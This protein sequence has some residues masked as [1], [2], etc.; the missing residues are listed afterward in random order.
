[1]MLLF[2]GYLSLL[3]DTLYGKTRVVS[4][5]ITIALLILVWDEKKK[6]EEV[7]I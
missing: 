1:M 2:G 4:A 5:L 6:L 7:E 3:F